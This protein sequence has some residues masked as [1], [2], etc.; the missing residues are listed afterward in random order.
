LELAL[1]EATPPQYGYDPFATGGKDRW[2]R[3]TD[4]K[5]PPP[6]IPNYD[7][8][9]LIGAGGMGAVWSAKYIPLNQP[10]AIKVL[11]P[12]L[13]MDMSLLERFAEEAKALARLDHPHIV[14]VYD[15]SADPKCPYMAMDFVAGQTLSEVLKARTLPQDEA[16]R[17]LGQIA[18]AIDY[19]HGHGFTHRDLKPSNIMISNAGQAT[20]ID[21]G[22]ATWLGGTGERPN[23]VAGTTRYLSPEAC[24]GKRV[25][26]ASDLW[27]FAVL[28]YRTLTGTLPF[29]G[30]S[31]QEVM[32]AILTKPPKE[33]TVA[34]PR[35][36]EVL[37][38]LF[39]K[40]PQAR[41]K[42]ATEMVERV[43]DAVRPIVTKKGLEQIAL[44]TS[45]LLFGAA[46]MIIV[47]A[48]AGYFLLRPSQSGAPVSHRMPKA[49]TPVGVSI[50]TVAAGDLGGI[51]YGTGDNLW[52]ELRLTPDE[53]GSVRYAL[54]VRAASGPVGNEGGTAGKSSD[55]S[56][57]FDWLS[58][59][60]S[61]CVF[62][63]RLSADHNRIVG[64]RTLADGSQAD[65][66]FY[67]ATDLPTTLYQDS[68]LH[69]SA[70]VPVGWQAAPGTTTT[71]APIGQPDVAFAVT[72]N[73]SGGAAMVQD[74]F[75]RQEQAYQDHQTYESYENLG[76]A[77]RTFAGKSAVAWKLRLKTVGGPVRHSVVIGWL[78]GDQCMT[79]ETWWPT[80]QEDMW[81]PILEAIRDKFVLTGG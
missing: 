59:S 45:F 6:D 71:I 51:W 35:L 65:Q 69:F 1:S 14:K 55:G 75:A 30:A 64:K 81:P 19:A 49:A 5:I 18:E 60:D 78:E 39:P 11:N 62:V 53:D 47:A 21:F 46:G 79:V 23:A 9:D 70:P 33:P 10:R 67:R 63:G 3:K 2:G 54:S 24:Q 72:A 20:L 4:S 26:M 15:I 48:V 36:R 16:I 52:E 58:T 74:F 41:A 40:D 57:K 56:L 42:T 66:D 29:D 37:R 61:K 17:Y 68:A 77:P 32:N 13:A 28:I 44:G 43:R 76:M 80:S 8:I 25:T 7:I 34:N 12:E 27:A 31:E 73:S 38:S 50:P 22:I